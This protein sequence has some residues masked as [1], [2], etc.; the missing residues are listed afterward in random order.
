MGLFFIILYSKLKEMIFLAEENQNLFLVLVLVLL[1][2]L[3]ILIYALS[4]NKQPQAFSE[5]YLG[6]NPEK[7]K[8]QEKFMAEFFIKNNEGQT[9]R[10]D[11][12]VSFEGKKIEKSLSLNDSALK[13][14][15]EEL[16]FSK[17]GKQR[18]LIEVRKES[19]QPE[20]ESISLWFWVEVE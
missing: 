13:K 7:I 17:T 2:A 3:I 16:Q 5:I 6:E 11:Y 18:V 10:Y 4:L 14:V 8:A 12:V 1:I 20:D 15:A 9:M 19:F